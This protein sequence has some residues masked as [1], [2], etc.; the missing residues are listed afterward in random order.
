MKLA[1]LPLILLPLAGCMGAGQDP[2]WVV[3]TPSANASFE[4]EGSDGSRLY[5][6]ATGPGRAVDPWFAQ[7]D[8]WFLEWTYAVEGDDPFTFQEALGDGGLILGHYSDCG[9]TRR[10]SLDDDNSWTC[11]EPIQSSIYG[12]YG[13]AGAFGSGPL[14]GLHLDGEHVQE[15]EILDVGPVTRIFD[16]REE[17]GCLVL[18]PDSPWSRVPRGLAWSHVESRTICPDVPLPTSF[19][20]HTSMPHASKEHRGQP[21]TYTLQEW[22]PGT[23]ASPSGE[24][25]V[26]QRPDWP[27]SSTDYLHV[28]DEAP[29][30]LT[31]R[32]AHEQAMQSDEAYRDIMENG[33]T[34]LRYR[35]F[36]SNSY[37]SAADIQEVR[38][39]EAQLDVQN[40]D[41]AASVVVSESFNEV[42]GVPTSDYTTTS[43]SL[44]R[45]ALQHAAQADF[46]DLFA[47]GERLHG[48][49]LSAEWV[50]FEHSDWVRGPWTGVPANP[51]FKQPKDTYNLWAFYQDPD[52]ENKTLQVP[53]YLVIDG[54]T[55][56]VIQAD[57]KR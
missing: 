42:A 9:A 51:M 27:A 49:N 4:Y 7:R 13:A 29:V 54:I 6:N 47:I 3:A 8:A 25:P 55:G 1:L 36:R 38:Q 52:Q 15:Y 2:G 28:M 14:W 31:L 44:D 43:Q 30:T 56:A 26:I 12:S 50:G 10:D 32:E 5:V 16:V 34:V 57:T 24:P 37:H 19:T 46:G 11:K 23:G 20:T 17:D 41:A 21:V 33:G 40:E 39:A 22:T 48:F 53:L 45:Q 18:E 35:H